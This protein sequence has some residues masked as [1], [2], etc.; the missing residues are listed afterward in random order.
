[1]VPHISSLLHKFCGYMTVADPLI[2]FITRI[3]GLVYNGASLME[4][5]TE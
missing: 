4:L 1:M 5:T 3:A 2:H